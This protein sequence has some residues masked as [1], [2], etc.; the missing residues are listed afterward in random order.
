MNSTVN[1]VMPRTIQVPSEAFKPT[2]G[3]IKRDLDHQ[4]DDMEIDENNDF[5][6]AKARTLSS[7]YSSS[8]R[9]TKDLEKCKIAS[10]LILK[11]EHDPVSLQLPSD[12]E[13]LLNF[14]NKC[15]IDLLQNKLKSVDL[16]TLKTPEEVSEYADEILESMQGSEST[17][18]PS[19]GYMRIQADVNEKMRAILIDWLIEVHF[20]FKLL[21]ETLF[22]SVNLIDRYLEVKEIERQRLQLLG[23]TA[24]WIA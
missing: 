1:K 22:I 4:S 24:M 10:E 12:E 8:L 21:P 9:A 14:R 5:N 6:A 15:K 18:L 3:L 16:L 19:Y 23:V 11:E 17:H 13:R 2:S 7:S 20:K